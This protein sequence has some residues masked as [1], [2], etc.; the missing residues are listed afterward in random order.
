[1]QLVLCNDY[2]DLHIVVASAFSEPSTAG[3]V[4]SYQGVVCH[5]RTI[6]Q[7]NS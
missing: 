5:V 2:F 6:I 1:M 3:G 4:G 7:N